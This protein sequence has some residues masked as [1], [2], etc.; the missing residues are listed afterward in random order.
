MRG[1]TILPIESLGTDLAGVDKMAGK[2]NRLDM[3]LDNAF[4]FV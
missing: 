1:E 2:V 4:L 3:A